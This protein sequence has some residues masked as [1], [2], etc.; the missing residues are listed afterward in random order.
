M[1]R[2]LI[3]FKLFPFKKY[4]FCKGN[5]RRDCFCLNTSLVKQVVFTD[6]RYRYTCANCLKISRQC[7]KQSFFFRLVHCYLCLYIYDHINNTYGQNV[8]LRNTWSLNWIKNAI[9]RGILLPNLKPK[10]KNK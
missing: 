1:C 6:L 7:Q 2:H 5:S 8:V 10:E 3:Y 9:L 4:S